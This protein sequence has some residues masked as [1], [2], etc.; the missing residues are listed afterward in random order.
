MALTRITVRS[1]P[2]NR[3]TVSTADRIDRPG[4]RVDQRQLRDRAPAGPRAAP[5]A[6]PP[7]RAPRPHPGRALRVG[8][9]QRLE[10]RG[11]QVAARRGCAPGS[12]HS[13]C[14]TTTSGYSGS[15]TAATNGSAFGWSASDLRLAGV[16]GDAVLGVDLPAQ[17]LGHVGVEPEALRESDHR[18]LRLS[19]AA[20]Q[21][22]RLVGAELAGRSAAARR[23]S[24]A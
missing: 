20:A 22:Q 10:H 9:G 19:A 13:S 5:G 16:V 14:T 23:P 7:P 15:S 8:I 17:E 4:D 6:A 24:R 18:R 21:E 1:P 3:S 12:A 2:W 11:D